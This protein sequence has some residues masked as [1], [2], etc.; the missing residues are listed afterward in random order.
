MRSIMRQFHTDIR[1]YG[2]YCLEEAKARLRA[3]VSATRLNWLW[4]LLEPILQMLVYIVIFG[5]IFRASTE[6]YPAYIFIGL[7][8]WRFFSSTLTRSAK[9][10]R[11]AKSLLWR[12]YIP[13]FLLVL[14]QML[15]NGFKM[16]VSYGIILLLLIWY[17]IPPSVHLLQLVPLLLLLWMLTFGLATII[18]HT[19]VY[20][21]DVNDLLPIILRLWMY[22]TGI[23]YSIQ[24]KVPGLFGYW[25]LRLNPLAFIL[26]G[27]RQTLLFQN[28]VLWPWYWFWLAISCALCLVGLRLLYRYGARYLKV[29]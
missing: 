3:E 1:L 24:D 6:Y 17:R 21:D 11:S 16:L 29:V 22:F 9:L 25:M 14:T 28:V 4:W 12:V 18:A 27:L 23:F 20:L 13:R 19:G 10:I 7:T 15:C 26:D 8:A 5:F 2:P